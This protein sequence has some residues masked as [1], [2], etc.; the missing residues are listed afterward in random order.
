MHTEVTL[1]TLEYDANHLITSAYHMHV[2]LTLAYITRQYTC[3]L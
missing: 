3:V 2:K 1:I